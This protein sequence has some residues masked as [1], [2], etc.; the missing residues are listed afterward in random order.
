MKG[1]GNGERRGLKKKE[2]EGESTNKA[3]YMNYITYIRL[4]L[5]VEWRKERE[6]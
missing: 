6:R 1:T 5:S 4:C 2:E 3:F